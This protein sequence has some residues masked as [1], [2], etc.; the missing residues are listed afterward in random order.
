MTGGKITVHYRYTK[1]SY[2]LADMP[3]IFQEKIDSTLKLEKPSW[4]EDI[5]V[6]TK[7][8][9]LQNFNNVDQKIDLSGFRAAFE[10]SKFLQKEIDWLGYNISEERMKPNLRKLSQL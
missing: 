2:G 7:G 5:L 6:V 10:K 9:T 1:K 3:I 4:Q 8:D